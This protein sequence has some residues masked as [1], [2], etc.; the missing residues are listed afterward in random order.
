VNKHLNILIIDDVHPILIDRLE[1]LGCRMDY[2]P[3]VAPEHI[4]QALK[5]KQ[6]LI[7]RSKISI[8]RAFMQRN[9]DLKIIG[10]AGSGMDNIDLDAAAELGIEC[11][12]A[13]E[14]NRDAVAEQAMAMLLSLLTRTVKSFEEVKN[15]IWDRE[16]NRGFELG[17][18]RV[19]IIG[20]G[21]TGSALASKLSG[22]GCR[23]L[24]YDKY[25]TGFGNDSVEEVGYEELLK[26]ADIIS[27]HVPL[28]SETKSWIDRRF[29][30]SVENSF[31]LLNLSRGGIMQTEAILNGLKAGRIRG[32][33]TDVLEN[34]KLNTYTASE[35]DLLEELRSRSDVII[36][37][38][39]GG[40]TAESYRK[41]SEVL[42]EK[43]EQYMETLKSHR[44]VDVN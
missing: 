18:M 41:I 33:A 31:Y 12:N 30:E 3:N 6:G 34:E 32:F 20:F 14:A 29:I 23:V 10:R 7:I 26:A 8:D 17:A 24:A 37:P 2:Q 35:K 19:G 13:A 16:G 21:N 40:W 43:I 36:T 11:I 27:F 5:G 25:K 1:R 44:K 42:A 9:P 22:F 4:D 39:I 15:G 28:T 38:H